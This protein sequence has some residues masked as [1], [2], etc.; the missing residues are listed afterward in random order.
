MIVLIQS[1]VKGQVAAEI[2]PGAEIFEAEI[3]A[4]F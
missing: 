4:V 3:K 1:T 2:L